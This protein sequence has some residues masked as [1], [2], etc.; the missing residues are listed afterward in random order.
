MPP[1]CTTET[2]PLHRWVRK[3][4]EHQRN[5]PQVWYAGRVWR[6][7]VSCR[8]IS[9]HE[10]RH[11]ADVSGHLDAPAARTRNKIFPVTHSPSPMVDSPRNH[12]ARCRKCLTLQFFVF[13]FACEKNRFFVLYVRLQVLAW[14]SVNDICDLKCPVG[15]I[16]RTEWR[17]LLTLALNGK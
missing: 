10:R 12:H 11:S 15:T 14:S 1:T 16:V 8:Y 9:T 6:G 4:A 5:T 7:T 17:K 2:S 3:V 13:F